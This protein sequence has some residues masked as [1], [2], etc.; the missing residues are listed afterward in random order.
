MGTSNLYSVNTI[1]A[2]GMEA[3]FRVPIAGTVF[4]PSAT[5]PVA[6]K[7]ALKNAINSAV[8]GGELSTEATVDSY[9][10]AAT[11]YFTVQDR[12]VMSFTGEDGSNQNYRIPAPTDGI[13][14][15]GSD[16][17]VDL[18]NA[19]VEAYVGAMGANA[20]T[21]ANIT[22][23]DLASGLRTGTKLEKGR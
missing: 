5:G 20:K 21:E 16:A 18:G 17:I 8:V 14:V 6:I 9:T 23:E 7:T 2:N 12:L 22:L 1:D 10:P 3:K 15:D 11:G 4:S 13:F 19:T